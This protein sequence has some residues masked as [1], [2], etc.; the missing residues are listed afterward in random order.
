MWEKNHWLGEE[1][2]ML[3]VSIS[4][5]QQLSQAKRT[6]GTE[7]QRRQRR[8]ERNEIRGGN[9]PLRDWGNS[10]EEGRR[11]KTRLLA[12]PIIPSIPRIFIEI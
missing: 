12:M 3:L 5:G 8:E 11:K 6:K 2:G 1:K 4:S 10:E 9:A 7:G